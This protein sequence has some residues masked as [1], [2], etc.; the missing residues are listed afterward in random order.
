M[1]TVETRDV[2]MPDGKIV[3]G[4][5]V[6]TSMAE[7]EA[8][9]RAGGGETPAMK[10]V[11]AVGRN[12]A[13]VVPSIGTGLLRAGSGIAGMPGDVSNLAQDLAA[14]YFGRPTGKKLPGAEDIR[15]GASTAAQAVGLPGRIFQPETPLGKFTAAGTEGAASMLSARGLPLLLGTASGMG[16][17]LAT[18]LLADT[19]GVRLAG[20]ATP[21][22]AA[23]IPSLRTP[24]IVT[25]LAKALVELKDKFGGMAAGKAAADKA[26]GVETLLSHQA[27]PNSGLRAVAQEAAATP[28][29][30]ALRSQVNAEEAALLNKSKLM[31]A[32]PTAVP[33]DRAAQIQ[34]SAAG[35]AAM[36][37]PVKTR[38]ALANPAYEAAA[39]DVT[40]VGPAIT[41][42][43]A[44]REAAGLTGN[45]GGKV[46]DDYV[47]QLAKMSG[48]SPGGV[49]IPNLAKMGN[50]ASRMANSAN[51]KAS[52]TEGHRI[53]AK[54]I[55]EAAQEASPAQA[56]ADALYKEVSKK[57]VE[58]I[59]EGVVGQSF[60]PQGEAAIG[61]RPWQTMAKVLDNPNASP[62]DITELATHLGNDKE[63]FPL[64]LKD[65]WQRAGVD[66][67]PGEFFTAIAGDT[68][69]VSGQ[70][71]REAFKEKVRQ[72]QIAHG[73]TETEAREAAEG[74]DKLATA[75]HT[76]S[77]GHAGMPG[78]PQMGTKEMAGEN[79]ASTGAR[80][81]GSLQGW[82][83]FFTAAHAVEQSRSRVVMEKIS[84]ALAG[85]GS[86][87][88]LREIAFYDPVK[89]AAEVLTRGLGSLGIQQD[90][91]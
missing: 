48:Q 11:N 68:S 74:A 66:K 38:A 76:V 65:S 79:L 58:P 50:E 40:S 22:A 72:A 24:N 90:S 89:H 64:L 70:A 19:P 61:P 39:S 31:Q 21:L 15:E 8:Q 37:A 84:D 35:D 5:P 23:L 77:S 14:Q 7:V 28:E 82:V 52:A 45:K 2:T 75:V 12:V 55:S 88:K 44:A 32:S 85:S 54:V 34:V 26:L 4:V 67:S 29:G 63:A 78:S 81:I 51:T 80:V 25:T 27:P 3:A 86:L 49:P 20:Q 87:D 47:Q 42:L 1:D 46:I 56:A 57:H 30:V 60:P 83:R 41:K 43:I 91:E 17:E 53:A 9:W 13:E 10:A 16:G 18:H 62:K 33:V 71:T 36:A 6:G 69:T 73:A 59:H